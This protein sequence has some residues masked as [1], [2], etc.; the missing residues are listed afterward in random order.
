MSKKEKAK[1][2][3]FTELE[4]SE[5]PGYVFG[6]IRLA[7]QEAGILY[8]H[9]SVQNRSKEDVLKEIKGGNIFVRS[10]GDVGGLAQFRKAKKMGMTTIGTCFSTHITYREGILT[11]IY[12][13]TG[14]D[15]RSAYPYRALKEE[16]YIDYY[17]SL[18]EFSKR[19]FVLGGISPE[20]I[21]VAHPGV[22][23]DTFCF[24]EQP[25]EFKILF[26]GTN[27]LRKGVIHLLE[28]WN[29]LNINAKLVIRSGITGLKN[30]KD[31]ISIPDWLSEKDLVALYHSCSLTILPS[32]E[33]G[34]PATNFES[35]ACGRPVI[36]TDATG[37]GEVVTDYND[38]VIIP[39]GDIRAI[40]DAILYFYNNRDELTRMGLNARKIAENYPW[41]RFRLRVAEIVNQIA[42]R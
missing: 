34:F 8:K 17:L 41:V 33:E 21:F 15:M 26:V 37:L 38:G 18:S 25:P 27:A 31:V 28:A 42:E 11:E 24:K 3:Y 12:K 32:L 40:M 13:A 9:E 2:I 23:A 36:A 30:V 14:A 5:G 10:V 6:Q 35:M 1:V 39:S 20:K 16:R 29:K 4:G 22:D 7:L 19:T